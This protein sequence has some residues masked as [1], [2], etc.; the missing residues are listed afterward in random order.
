[1]VVSAGS[2]KPMA[3]NVRRRA[4]AIPVVLAFGAGVVADAYVMWSGW[5]WFGVAVGALLLAGIARLIRQPMATVLCLLIAVAGVGAVRHHDVWSVGTAN[6]VGLFAADESR[7]VRLI[8]SIRQRPII[9]EADGDD[10][11]RAGSDT[12]THHVDC[13]LPATVRRRAMTST[14][15][16]PCESMSVVS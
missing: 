16:V 5:A 14:C 2:S 10:A 15:P 11:L 13:L 8:G 6:D 7:P 4:P 3:T 1:M 12:R 9:L